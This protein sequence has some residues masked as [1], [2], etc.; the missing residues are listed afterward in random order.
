M[1][2]FTFISQQRCFRACRSI[3]SKVKPHTRLSLH[4]HQQANGK[5]LL[6]SFK[7][8]FIFILLFIS[9]LSYAQSGKVFRDFN[10]NGTQD[11][12]EP[13]V[14]GIR[15]CAY[16]NGT[17]DTQ[18]SCVNTSSTGTYTLTGTSGSVRVE[19]TIPSNPNCFLDPGIDFPSISGGIYGTSVQFVNATTI[20]VNF[21]I[22]A[23]PQYVPNT[24][25]TK[26]FV[27][28]YVNG[29]NRLAGIKD[30]VAMV[31]VDYA[32]SGI[33]SAQKTPIAPVENSVQFGGRFLEAG[34]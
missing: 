30:E 7:N 6:L 26:L 21:A 13:G 11:A 28:C 24:T 29:D 27:P 25:D 16:G 17:P 22:N 10:G 12:N 15:V 34:E 14:S 31:K 20:N 8:L 4:K 23:P 18:I 9:S 33:N 32:A 2:L 3:I 5:S 19:F 1:D